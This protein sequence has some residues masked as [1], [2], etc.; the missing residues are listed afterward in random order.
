MS[1]THVRPSLPSGPQWR[2]ACRGD[3][4]AEFWTDTF[5]A[6][7]AD[8]LAALHEVA[9]L[10]PRGQVWPCDSIR[11]ADGSLVPAPGNRWGLVHM[12]GNAGEWLAESN[13]T[14]M[15]P[16]AGGYL[17]ADDSV[18]GCARFDELDGDFRCTFVGMRPTRRLE[19]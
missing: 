2:F 10:A 15:R 13:E 19:R 14:R 5:P 12:H 6:P 16:L 4:L 9:N 17:G 7:P 8:R 18:T 3:D 11:R 1:G